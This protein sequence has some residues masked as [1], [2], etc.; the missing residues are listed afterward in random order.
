MADE[1]KGIYSKLNK[2]YKYTKEARLALWP[3]GNANSWC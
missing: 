2:T 3:D 1:R